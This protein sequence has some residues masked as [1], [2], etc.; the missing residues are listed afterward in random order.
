MWNYWNLSLHDESSVPPLVSTSTASDTLLGSEWHI[1]QRRWPPTPPHASRLCSSAPVQ[2][3]PW[4]QVI[5]MH[6]VWWKE[7]EKGTSWMLDWALNVFWQPLIDI[8][9]APWVDGRAP[10]A[11]GLLLLNAGSCRRVPCLITGRLQTPR[12]LLCQ[13]GG[14]LGVRSDILS[15]CI[16]LLSML[17]GYVIFH[18]SVPIIRAR[19]SRKDPPDV[20]DPFAI[21]LGAAPA[22]PATSKPYTDSVS[23]KSSKSTSKKMFGGRMRLTSAPVGWQKHCAGALRVIEVSWYGNVISGVAA[24]KY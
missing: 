15:N 1:L 17:T 21:G 6:V 3:D 12:L 7:R 10:P 9:D 11:G 4:T 22:N 2:M 19:L 20:C 23:A 16:I 24:P 8:R 18:R 13:D 14:H 5:K